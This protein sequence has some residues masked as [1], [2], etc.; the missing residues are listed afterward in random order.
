MSNIKNASSKKAGGNKNNIALDF[1][2]S[3]HQENL[4][5]RTDTGGTPSYSQ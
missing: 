4:L 5:V 3:E 1:K 2:D